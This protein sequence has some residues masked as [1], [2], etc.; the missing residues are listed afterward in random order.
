MSQSKL[1][2]HPFTGQSLEPFPKTDLLIQAKSLGIAQ[3]NWKKVAVENRCHILLKALNYF[4]KHRDEVAD[5]ISNTM[6]RP[7]SQAKGEIDGLL[8]RARYLTTI[9]AEVLRPDS[10]ETKEG[11]DRSITHEPLGVVFVISAWNYPLLVTINGVFASL[12]AG[13]TVLLKHATQTLEI[14]RHFERAFGQI[15]DHEGILAQ[16]IAGHPDVG[17][18]IEK[19]RI[20]HVIFTGSVEGGRTVYTSAARGLIDCQLELGGKDGA[21]VAADAD[22]EQAAALLVDGALYNSG[23]SCCGVERVYVHESV[24]DRFVDCCAE[25]MSRH[26]LG[27]PADPATTM[28]PLAQA[29]AADV[30]EQQIHDA[31]SKGAKI[32]YGGHRLDIESGVFFEPTLVTETDHTMKIMHEENFGPLL[33]VMRVPSDEEG[34]RLVNDSHYGLT[35]IICTRNK[36]LAERFFTET[37]VGTV[38]MNRCDYLDPALPWTGVGD[39]GIGSALSKYGLLGVT[40]RKAK[41]FRTT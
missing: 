34:F 38:F 29:V 11:F 9:A 4:E 41:H 5:D 33:P 20:D 7:F 27:D 36:A 23:Q 6:G 8:E 24:H 13:N 30:L 2:I 37:T 14:G 40:R 19:R 25:L 28:G 31:R 39:S 16:A 35:A 21:Y 3:Q 10:L 12:L 32:V 1:R 15:P 22:I 17:E 26:V 18:L